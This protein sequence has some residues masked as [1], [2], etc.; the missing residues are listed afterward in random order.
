[1]LKLL[2]VFP[3]L[4]SPL[5]GLSQFNTVRH[6]KA[7]PL[8]QIDSFAG[9]RPAAMPNTV[10]GSRQGASMPLTS[11]LI[12]SPYG[13]RFDPFSGEAAY[14]RGIDFSASQDSVL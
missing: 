13:E 10:H 8:V 7:L 11:L 5:L 9:N 2:S 14:H 12:N 6:D 4:L 1:M 3:L